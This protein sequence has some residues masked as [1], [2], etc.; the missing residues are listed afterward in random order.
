MDKR[1]SVY[2]IRGAEATSW[3]MDAASML[4][5]RSPVSCHYGYLG[6]CRIVEVRWHYADHLRGYAVLIV[7]GD[8]LSDM[9]VLRD[10]MKIAA[11]YLGG[12]AGPRLP[13]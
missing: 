4:P 3:H 11:V 12:E 13:M 2:P 9:S 6:I 5:L 8:P 7:D 10:N 1:A